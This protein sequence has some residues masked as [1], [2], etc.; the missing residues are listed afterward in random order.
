LAKNLGDDFL[1]EVRDR[2]VGFDMHEK[3]GIIIY[4]WTNPGRCMLE[5]TEGVTSTLERSSL[6]TGEFD[7]TTYGV[8]VIG[9][10]GNHSGKK[11]KDPETKA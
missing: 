9:R 1:K 11:T 5:T 10:A 2:L 6:E 7:I 8:C 4:P 3:F